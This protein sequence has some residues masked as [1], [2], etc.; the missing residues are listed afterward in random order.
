LIDVSLL[1][2]LHLLTVLLMAWTCATE[3]Q[4]SEFLSVPEPSEPEAVALA[5]A[6]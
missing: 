1:D 5:E 6:Q 3:N 4:L 2:E